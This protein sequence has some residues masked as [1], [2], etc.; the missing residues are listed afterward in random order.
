MEGASL[1]LILCYGFLGGILLNLMPCVFP[2]LAIKIY[3]LTKNVSRSAAVRNALFFS[4]G[5]IFSA[6][7]LA[8]VFICFRSFGEYV[9]WGFQLQ[10]P[11]FLKLMIYLFTLLTL[12]FL[13]FL[14]VGGSLAAFFGKKE[15]KTELGSPFGA[16]LSGCLTTLVATPC[17]APFMGAAIG[18]GLLMGTLPFLL[19]ITALGCGMAFPYFILSLF[20]HVIAYL[21]K[22]GIW[23]VRLKH[24]LALPL[25]GTALWLLW[26]LYSL[27]GLSSFTG[28]V[29]GIVVIYFM[30]MIWKKKGSDRFSFKWACLF[31]FLI[32][33]T[34]PSFK[35]KQLNNDN[36]GSSPYLAE[37]LEWI[38]FSPTTLESLKRSGRP[39][40]LDFTAK[41]CLTCQL[42]KKVVFSSDAV[43]SLLKEKNVALV[44]GDWTSRSAEIAAALEKFGRISVP[45]TVIYPAKNKRSLFSIDNQGDKESSPIILPPILTPQ[46]V[47]EALNKE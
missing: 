4:M 21:P 15:A 47:I 37:D 42:N 29:L 11:I 25:F 5:I 38:E 23:M 1:F 19:I 24:F 18:A 17:S 41:W 8:A 44:R 45:M 20:P 35:F 2:V 6:L 28:G 22:S 32:L 16:F 30:A 34:L 36:L 33:L 12:F 46:L 10:S 26:V 9:G 27:E 7:L 39:I 14:E 13:D 31:L 40:Y 43:L 3:G